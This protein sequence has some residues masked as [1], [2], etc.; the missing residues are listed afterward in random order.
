MKARKASKVNSQDQKLDVTLVKERY[1][2]DEMFSGQYISES[3]GMYSKE[4]IVNC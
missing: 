2:L 3:M 4:I 1:E